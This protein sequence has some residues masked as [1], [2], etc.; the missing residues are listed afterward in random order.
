MLL[1]LINPT[2]ERKEI[3]NEKPILS[4]LVDNSLSIKHLKK[5][6]EVTTLLKK[7]ESNNTLHD[8]FNVQ[9][10]KFGASLEVLDS[11]SFSE[12]QTNIYK[13]ITEVE[14]LQKK[15]NSPIILVSDGNQTN[16]NLYP[17]TDTSKNVFPLVIGDTLTQTDIRISQLNVNKYSYLQNK[18]PVEITVLY[19]GSNSINS[20]I[21]IEKNGKP[22]YRKNLKLNAENNVKTI[23]TTLKSSKEGVQYYK[24]YVKR[25]VG[26]KNIENNAK[27]FSVEVLNEQTKVLILTSV[28]HPDL[29]A[30][31]KAT[32][33]N[34]QRSIT[35]VNN[36]DFKGDL[37]D[38]QLVIL[39]QPTIKFKSIFEKID[40]LKSNYFVVTGAKTNWNFLNEIQPNYY[41]NSINQI[42]NF[43]PVFN[44][45]FLTFGQKDIRFESFSPLSDLF[46]KINMKSKFDA[47]LYQNILGIN[48]KTPLLAT[49]ENGKQKSG[50]LFGEGIWKWRANSFISTNS[51]QDFDAFVGNLIQYLASKKKRERLS[52]N[53]E[54]LY[55]ANTPISLTAFY[56]DKNYQFDKRA[57]ISVELV[58]LETKIRQ[59]I[60]FSLHNNSYEAILDNLP[61]G[62]YEFDVVV[63]KQNIK[64]HGQFKITNY[65]IEEQFTKANLTDLN[66]LALQTKGNVY[67]ESNIEKLLNDLVF[68]KRYN[69]VQKSKKVNQ[70]LIEWQY[71]L[72]LIVLL[73]SVEWFIRKYIGKI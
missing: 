44:N 22:V 29:G 40:A 52:I 41:K 18:F 6:K 64:K 7:V 33:T 48:T 27:T 17:Y 43:A 30:F 31:K 35:I 15:T 4:I 8:K 13:A 10:Y 71:I 56:V 1:L 16:G 61:P 58:N 53:Y 60:P 14:T 46:G 21:I 3:T 69:T 28:L 49:F 65:Q 54:K 26:E 50:V 45:G 51:F 5:E 19:D 63:N 20:Q 36:D 38:Y 42:E 37:A 57:T 67:F 55:T 62:N 23:L 47:L 68:D 9:L 59:N 2:I 39:Y 73:F 72:F 24:A 70:Y 34:K 66:L 12:K 25:I 32:E 11:L